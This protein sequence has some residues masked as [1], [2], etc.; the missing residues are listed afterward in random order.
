MAYLSEPPRVFSGLN[1]DW[2]S[3][4]VEA[5]K[6]SRARRRAYLQT[7]DELSLMS[8]RELADIGL[9]SLVVRDVALEAAELVQAG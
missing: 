5:H 8:E 6:L 3:A 4:L 1:L 9:C 7:L 2:I